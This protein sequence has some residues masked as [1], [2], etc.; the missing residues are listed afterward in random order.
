M[1]IFIKDDFYLPT[2]KEYGFKEVQTEKKHS[3][4]S[5]GVE[6]DVK[7]LELKSTGKTDLSLFLKMYK[8]NILKITD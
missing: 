8:D 5:S 4:Q 7:T 2:L 3:Y 6:I 1:K